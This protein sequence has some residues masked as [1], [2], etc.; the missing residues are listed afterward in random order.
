MYKHLRLKEIL[1]ENNNNEMCMF[2]LLL[3]INNNH[4]D[5]IMQEC[6]YVDDDDD[7]DGIG[8]STLSGC[9]SKRVED[10]RR[11]MCINFIYIYIFK[12]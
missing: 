5:L 10:T 12:N 1:Y 2:L 4:N 9:K 8:N 6:M 7:D 11:N 3:L